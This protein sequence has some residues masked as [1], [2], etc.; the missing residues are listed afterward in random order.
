[1]I[2]TI[3]FKSR[4]DAKAAVKSIIDYGV[5][6]LDVDVKLVAG[7]TPVRK[8]WV[9]DYEG[10]PRYIAHADYLLLFKDKDVCLMA[11]LVYK[12]FMSDENKS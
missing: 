4:H 12:S 2:Y 1:M 9:I 7:N 5:A 10:R 6:V 11:E 3:S 8:K